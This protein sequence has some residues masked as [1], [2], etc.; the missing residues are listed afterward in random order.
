MHT[1]VPGFFGASAR[2]MGQ[3]L[4]GSRKCGQRSQGMD[5]ASW[6][7][8]Q[9]SQLYALPSYSKSGPQL[10]LTP[11]N[12]FS[13]HV[14][15]GSVLLQMLPTMYVFWGYYLQLRHSHAQARV[16]AHLTK[17]HPN[18][19][20]PLLEQYYKISSKSKFKL[21]THE[22]PLSTRTLA[23]LLIFPVVLVNTYASSFAPFSHS[24]SSCL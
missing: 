10:P 6:G 9:S 20:F 21:K 14:D 16:H 17:H 22:H 11:P 5:R 3:P 2:T 19:Q 18:H 15:V 24:A 12:G 1:H 4:F 13:H 8:P 23:L 7:S